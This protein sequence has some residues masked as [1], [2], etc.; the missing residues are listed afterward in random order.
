MSERGGP[1]GDQVRVTV[2]VAVVPEMAFQI[3][4]EEIDKW[5]RRGPR[6]RAS[7][8]QSGIMQLEPWIGGRL[9][10]SLETEAGPRE[11]VTGRVTVWEPPS[12]LVFQWRGL[13]FAPDEKTEVEVEFAASRSGTSVTVTHRGWSSL[14]EDHPARHGHGPSDF[15]QMLGMWWRDLMTSL[16]EV[17]G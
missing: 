13:N 15:C 5:W 8:G 12:R 11:M 2:L 4:T 17:A 14:R 9:L 16:R 7:S 10:E 6:F 1:P 3:F